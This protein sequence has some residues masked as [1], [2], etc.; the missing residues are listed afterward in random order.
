M[1][2]LCKYFNQISPQIN[3]LRTLM[4]IILN[5]VMI[6]FG[7]ENIYNLLNSFYEGQ[8][9]KWFYI[10]SWSSQYVSNRLCQ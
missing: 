8:Y 3:G 5:Y 2:T 4:M 9:I 7:V 6:K 10:Y 1:E